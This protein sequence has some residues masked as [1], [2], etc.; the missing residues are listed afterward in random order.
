MAICHILLRSM[1]ASHVVLVHAQHAHVFA[2]ALTSNMTA[3][4]VVLAHEHALVFAM[5][6]VSK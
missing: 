3:S 1:S 6:L 2:T 5:A 4:R